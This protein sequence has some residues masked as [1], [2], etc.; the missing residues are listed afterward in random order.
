[1]KWLAQILAP[2]FDFLKWCCVTKGW[3]PTVMLFFMI[4]LLLGISGG[5][6]Y[7]NTLKY[8]IPP[9]NPKYVVQKPE[10]IIPEIEYK[11]RLK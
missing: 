1:M 6:I 10:S 7:I 11:A 2:L 9:D 8:A 4:F 3:K 5:V